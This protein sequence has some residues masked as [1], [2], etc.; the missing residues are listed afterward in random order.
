M[1][2]E[3]VDRLKKE[4]IEALN[5]IMED[6]STITTEI[7]TTFD[8]PLSAAEI[9]QLSKHLSDNGFDSFTGGAGKFSII[10]FGES[11]EGAYDNWVDKLNNTLKQYFNGQ[12][13]N[14][15]N[16]SHRIKTWY[17]AA[18]P[19]ETRGRT[20]REVKNNLQKRY[21]EGEGYGNKRRSDTGNDGEKGHNKG[22]SHEDNGKSFLE[23]NHSAETQKFLTDLS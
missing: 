5:D 19:T 8:K 9:V 13:N 21:S 6:G 23:E 22:G 12:T 7:I 1:T 10:Y 3:D 17:Q 16:G 11:N 14:F 20:Y 4:G 2:E 15:S 18:D